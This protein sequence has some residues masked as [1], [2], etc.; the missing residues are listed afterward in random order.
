[1]TED[2]QRWHPAL[3]LVERCQK[4][5]VHCQLL[6]D[7]DDDLLAWFLRYP[8]F[9]VEW[10]PYTFVGSRGPFDAYSRSAP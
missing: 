7:R 2:L 6:E 10:R 8:A 5:N 3:V 4:A 9:A 1:M